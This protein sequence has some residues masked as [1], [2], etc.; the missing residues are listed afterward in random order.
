MMDKAPASLVGEMSI[1]DTSGHK[2]LKWKMDQPDAIAVA[3]Q[4][5]DALVKDGYSAFGSHVR[6]EPKQAVKEFDPTLEDLVM[7]PRTVGG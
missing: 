1:M 2:Q 3:K 4:T 5:F 7:V 6:D